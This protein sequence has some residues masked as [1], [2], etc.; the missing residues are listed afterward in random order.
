MLRDGM[1][2]T[3]IH[4][5]LAPY[6]PNSIDDAEPLVADQADGGYV[7][8][9]RPIEGGA[10][11]AQPLSFDDHFSQATMFFRSLTAL[12]QAHIVEAFTF[13]LGKC[14]EQSIKERECGCWPMSTLNCVRRLRPAS[15]CRHRPERRPTWRFPALLTGRRDP[16]EPGPVDGRKVGIIAGA[17]SDLGGCLHPGR[18]RS[19]GA[20]R[21]ARWSTAPVGGVPEAGRRRVDRRTGR[22][23]RPR[24]PSQSDAV[25]VAGRNDAD[26]TI[27]KLVRAAAGGVPA[28]QGDSPRVG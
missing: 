7:P 2:Q 28:L 10:V 4:T 12:E 8:T 3:A 27:I 15:A 19:C 20:R 23:P 9:P 24:G 6:L 22:S 11:R 26:R 5:G 14:Y 16:A 21:D 25:V 13:E 18:R 1:H 17:G